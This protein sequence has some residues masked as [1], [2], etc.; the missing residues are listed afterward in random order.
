MQNIEVISLSRSLKTMSSEDLNYAKQ[1]LQELNYNVSFSKN[2]FICDS[3]LSSTISERIFDFHNALKSKNI[4]IIL[5]A[6]GGYNCHQLLDYIDYDLIKNNP[7]KICGYSD[8]TVL[9]NA[10]YKMTGVVTFLGPTFQ[11][12]SMRKGLETTI[13][14][15]YQVI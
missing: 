14:S 5:S 8:N 1:K 13:T 4:A 6:K 9:L 2:S 3:F 12:F 10:I 7:K 11:S 15:F